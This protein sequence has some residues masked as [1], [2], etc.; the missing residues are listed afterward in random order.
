MAWRYKI[1][2]PAL[3]QTVITRAAKFSPAGLFSGARTKSTGLMRGS[4]EAITM[5]YALAAG[6]L[7]VL[8]RCW[9][10]SILGSANFARYRSGL[11]LGF[12]EIFAPLVITIEEGGIRSSNV[13]F[14]MSI[15]LVSVYRKI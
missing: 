12:W 3:S 6:L 11:G 15:V 8:E 4:G 5:Y 13:F 2:L 7:A 9:L 14:C 1:R 10:G